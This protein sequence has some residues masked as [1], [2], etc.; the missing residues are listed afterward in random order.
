MRLRCVRD[1]HQTRRGEDS[2]QQAATSTWD[3][4]QPS[5]NENVVDRAKSSNYLLAVDDTEITRQTKGGR[6]LRRD[7]LPWEAF[8]SLRGNA[9]KWS[10]PRRSKAGD[11]KELLDEGKKRLERAEEE[12]LLRQR[13]QLIGGTGSGA[14]D[15]LLADLREPTFSRWKNE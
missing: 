3:A 8:L 7:A 9:A 5:V 15:D 4:H 13:A 10:G 1:A 12:E 6:I 2:R 11:F 14:L